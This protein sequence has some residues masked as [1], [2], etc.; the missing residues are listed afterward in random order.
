MPERLASRL[1]PRW[2]KVVRDLATNKVRTLL[3]VLSIA[4][5]VF[6]VGATIS[7]QL[8]FSGDLTR[9]W[10]AINPASATI[11]PDKPFDEELVRA[12]RRVEGVGA[13]EGSRH[14]SVRVKIGPDEWRPLRLT[15]RED[16]TNQHV[17]KIRSLSGAWPP[18]RREVVIERG[19]LSVLKAMVGGT[20]AIETPDGKLHEL[21]IAGL[22]HELSAPPVFFTG[23][24]YGYI[25][26]ETMEWLRFPRTY[27]QLDFVVSEQ[28][29]D[30]QHIQAV[31]DLVKH[32]VEQTGRVVRNVDILTPGKHPADESIQPLL[33]IMTLLG[34]F[35][36]VLSGFLVVNTVTAL[37]TQQVPQ[38]G[39]MKAVGARA[40]Q[41][42]AMYLTTVVV[43]GLLAFLVA[44][45]LSAGAAYLLTTYLSNLVNLDAGDLRLPGSVL[46]LEFAIALLVP[47]IAA[48]WP[49]LSGTR[50]T[51]RQAL[52]AGNTNSGFGRSAVDRL[53]ERVRGL[54]RPLL[55]S[56]RNTFRRKARLAL[57]L[58]TLT[59]GGAIFVAVL[60]VHAS[61]ITTF[62]GTLE[63]WKYDVE[64]TMADSYRIDR[65]LDEAKQVPGVVA[66][67]GW[68]IGSL[69]RIRPDGKEGDNLYVIAAPAETTIIQPT[70]IAGRWLQPGDVDAVVLNTAATKLE[71][72]V[73]VGQELPVKIDGKETT[74][75]VVGIARSAMT[76]PL[77]YVDIR[78][79][80][81]LTHTQ[82]RSNQVNVVTER[83]DGAS[84]AAVAKALKERLDEARLR[85]GNT[86]TLTS[87]RDNVVMQMNVI[88]GLL[89]VMAVL[90][91]VVGGLGL[92]GTMGI[93]VL[94]RM[95]EIGVMRAIGAPTGA[96]IRIVVAEGIVIAI[97][98]WL[99]GASLGFPMGKLLSDGIGQGM[100]NSQLTYTFSS[101]G[102]LLWLVIVVAL[103]ALASLIPAIRASRITVRAVLAYE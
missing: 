41:L 73:V 67:E 68:A 21:P 95:R 47:I 102:T 57:T 7:T 70:L 34:A 99:L 2:R 1:A 50:M 36:L 3:V 4:V 101:A 31:A 45:P 55:L 92:M 93:N 96:I 39:M 19:S 91:A 86:Q 52:S 53:I 12:V 97:L 48:L 27:S 87:I 9:A 32:K 78:T 18:P 38:L 76:G 24:A 75:Q 26:P 69:R 56:L 84:Q 94:E 17:F 25:T 65:L 13:A 77:V 74:L 16:Y 79:F 14:V 8:L 89:A 59:M 44:V 10:I 51:V 23:T 98:S 88:A 60:S 46:A 81:R 43:Y 64:L 83:H 37:L 49:V 66:A 35:S 40:H 5:G 22:A 63:Y 28:A 6:A 100:L 80:G 30:K 85:V 61:L 33:L 103:A 71:P 82:G 58:A 62:D 42:L 20:I 72:D 29:H 11:H 90:M 54:S 15:A